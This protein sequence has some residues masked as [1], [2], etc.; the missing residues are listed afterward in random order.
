MCGWAETLEERDSIVLGLSS[1]PKCDPLKY[2][3]E[4]DII[5]NSSKYTVGND[6]NTDPLSK[7]NNDYDRPFVDANND[8]N[9]DKPLAYV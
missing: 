3:R 8:D 1:A 2:A 5:N 7:D 4:G 9:D 6:G